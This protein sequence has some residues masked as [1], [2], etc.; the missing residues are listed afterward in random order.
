MQFT[1][2]VPRFADSERI[3]VAGLAHR[4]NQK[5][6]NQIPALWRRF[7][8]YTA[9]IPAKSGTATY[10]VCYN[11]GADGSFDYLCGV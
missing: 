6:K 10:G 5:T 7:V 3:L 9:S 11:Y 4:Y 1:P 2:N 8:P